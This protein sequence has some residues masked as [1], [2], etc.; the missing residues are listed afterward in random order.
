MALRYCFVLGF[1]IAG[2]T[3]AVCGASD[4]GPT[5]NGM[6][7]RPV[8]FVREVRPIL[9]EHC[10]TCHGPDDDKRKAGLRLDTKEG[11]F[12]K[13]DGGDLAVVPKTPDESELI[14]RIESDDPD[15]G[16]HPGRAANRC[17]PSRSPCSGA[18]SSK[19]P[20]GRRTGPS[21]R[22]GGRSC[23]PSRDG[24]GAMA[25]STGSSWPG[26]KPRGF[27]LARGRQAGLDPPR[28][29]GPDGPAPDSPGGRRL[30][31]RFVAGGL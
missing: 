15:C 8:S 16:C 10:F 21:N 5:P 17:Q 9:A 3:A 30:P 4:S 27:P 25:R 28:H 1:L 20:P 13:L 2:G 26:W 22:R 14:F 24:G 31:G 6:A 12:A 29:P 11:A 19:G 23:P 18:G 7:P